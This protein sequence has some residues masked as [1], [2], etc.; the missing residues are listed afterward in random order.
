M[1][2]ETVLL[3]EAVD[4]LSI[5]PDGIYV[6]ATFGRGGHSRLILSRLGPQGRLIICDQDLAAIQ[7]AQQ[8]FEQDARVTILHDNFGQL[9]AHLRSLELW[10]KISGILFD[11]GVSSPQLDEAE[12]GFSFMRN[13][14]L[15]MRM[16]QTRGAPLSQKIKT[17]E[18][19]ELIRI[20]KVYGEEKF[21][22]K[23]A[24]A[25]LE[26]TL[27]T[28]KDLA[29]LIE[30]AIPKRFQEL[31]K[32][33]ATRTFQALRI[34]I[35]EELSALEKVLLLFPEMLAISGRGVFIS[36]HS[37]EDRLVKDRMKTLTSVKAH[38][39]GL[40]IAVNEEDSPSMQVCIKMQKPGEAEIKINPR[41]RSAVLRV[42]ERVK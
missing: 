3:T 18:K 27:S 4:A 33:P 31:H 10:G 2:H 9:E 12:R 1:S 37:L 42:M 23:I 19:A 36:F 39:R 38:A 41:A 35:N 28:T 13:G 20:L 14:P 26:S 34:W 22:G 25:I 24:D 30:K 40:P 8:E 32:H 11:L 16:N 17:L 5:Q 29:E 7:T 6:D 21:A 15:D